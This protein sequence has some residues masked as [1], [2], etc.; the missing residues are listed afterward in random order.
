MNVDP[1]RALRIL[2]GADAAGRARGKSLE[3]TGDGTQASEAEES[4][5]SQTGG[6]RQYLSL[7]GSLPET[8]SDRVST[9]RSAVEQGTYQ[10]SVD[11]LA[12]RLTGA[13]A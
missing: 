9:L 11:E 12:R 8:R 2:A 3:R 7:V 1:T 4:S 6:L 13:G 5:P 10:V